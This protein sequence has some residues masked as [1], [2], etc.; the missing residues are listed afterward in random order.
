V[1]RND[2]TG[3]RGEESGFTLIELLVAVTILVVGVFGLVTSVQTSHKL[4]DVAEHET[5]AS[6]VADRELNLALAIPYSFV[7]LSTNVPASAAATDDG[8]RW[9][10]WLTSGMMSHP[11]SSFSCSSASA[12]NRNPTLPNDEQSIGCIAACPTAGAA[13]CPGVG[14]LAPVSTVSVPTA[15]GSVR[16][17]K[18]YR[19]VTWVNDLSCGS[20]C[21]NPVNAGY[22]GDYKRVTIAVLPVVGGSATSGVASA[23]AMNGPKQPVVVSAIRNDPTLGTHNASSSDPSPCSVG[24]IE[25]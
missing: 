25:C 1:S 5:V 20:S 21:P 15:S 9:N 12:S 2:L 23:Q 22:K 24:G 6:H 17:L 16:L 19:Y 3:R 18:V 7:A 13:G 11:S 14:K 8:T 4:S 10:S